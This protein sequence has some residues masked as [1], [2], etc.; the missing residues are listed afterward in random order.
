MIILFSLLFLLAVVLL[1]FLFR[2]YTSLPYKIALLILPFNA[3]A[4]IM[5]DFSLLGEI[6]FGE[7]RGAILLIY[8]LAMLP[9]IRLNGPARTVV[10]W[11]IYLLP[12]IF[13]SSDIIYSFQVY[14]K[15][16]IAYLMLPIGIWLFRSKRSFSKLCVS[17]VI[18]SYIYVIG[19]CI[20]QYF[21]LGE[22][23][24]TDEG[25]STFGGGQAKFTQI[26]TYAVIAFPFSLHMSDSLNKQRIV[27][28]LGHLA[29]AIIII[30]VFHRSSIYALLFGYLVLVIVGYQRK[31]I[32]KLSLIIL[33]VIF[34]ISTF[35]YPSMYESL[36]VISG[37]RDFLLE[38][39]FESS[40]GRLSE[41]YFVERNFTNYT[42]I[43]ILF[44]QEL[45][46]GRVLTDSYRIY[47]SARPL[48]IDYV[49]V[50]LGAGVVGLFMYF[51]IYWKMT[52]SI[53]NRSKSLPNTIKKGYLATF[54][55]L[56]IACLSMS[57]SNQ[58]WGLSSLSTFFLFTGA[59]IGFPT[60]FKKT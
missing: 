12:L 60:S 46:N 19:F 18:T 34:S 33:L 42:T 48:H 43:E 15:V 23:I 20:F 55:G 38:N 30:L 37:E 4:D 26:L 7:I 3:I 14:S 58:I 10:I 22:V 57:L 41:L 9:F 2:S 17:L 56:L 6:H 27:H 39:E 47:K 24:Y 25:F 53:I 51:Y 28:I 50:L 29:S 21:D 13:F 59:M 11:L 40:R 16:V 45:F 1:V 5:V 35:F 31:N 32:L 49:V 44:G 52:L 54:L 36:F 8:V